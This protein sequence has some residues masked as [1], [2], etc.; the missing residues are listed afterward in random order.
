M[1]QVMAEGNPILIIILAFVLIMSI[2]SVI[3][4]ICGKIA[5]VMHWMWQ[6][7]TANK[8]GQQ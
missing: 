7:L 8:G 5:F 3:S 4:W 1:E 2:F 6:R